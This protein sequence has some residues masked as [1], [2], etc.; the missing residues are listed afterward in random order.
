MQFFLPKFFGATRLGTP[1]NGAP[2]INFLNVDISRNLTDKY[3]D[4]VWGCH[5]PPQRTPKWTPKNQFFEW[6]NLGCQFV[7][8]SGAARARVP[9]FYNIRRYLTDKCFDSTFLEVP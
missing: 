9:V 3:F 6:L 4:I 1:Q 7:L 2:K 8:I 5:P